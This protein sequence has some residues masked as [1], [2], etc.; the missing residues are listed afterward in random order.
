MPCEDWEV[1][2]SPQRAQ[3]KVE[4]IGRVVVIR[5]NVIRKNEDI[6]YLALYPKSGR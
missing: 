1:N 5:K 4:N 6:Y 3:L 2:S